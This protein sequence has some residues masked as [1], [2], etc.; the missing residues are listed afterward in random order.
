MQVHL[1]LLVE[2]VGVNNALEALIRTLLVLLNVV[3]VIPTHFLL[4]VNKIALHVRQVR[5]VRLSLQLVRRVLLA[6][7]ALLALVSTATLEITLIHQAAYNVNN[8][9]LV[10]LVHF[11][12]F[13]CAH[14]A[15]PV[16]SVTS[17][18]LLSA[19]IV[20]LGELLRCELLLRAHFV[21][22][23]ITVLV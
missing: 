13:L 19:K 12:L 21:K 3:N 17:L 10:L 7:Q 1:S 20:K 2:V 4:L 5:L 9:L 18:V 11:L 6:K 15:I 23:A 14:S 16:R 8:A 22:K